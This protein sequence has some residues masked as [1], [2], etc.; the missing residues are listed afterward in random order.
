MSASSNLTCGT[1]FSKPSLIGNVQIP[2]KW[3]KPPNLL[4]TLSSTPYIRSA[5]NE[6][7]KCETNMALTLLKS[8]EHF[9]ISNRNKSQ[10]GKITEESVLEMYLKYFK[11]I[12]VIG[13]HS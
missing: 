12:K 6:I 13:P 9:H 3:V 4:K 10:M 1:E 11:S 2:L 5:Q 7:L 8:K